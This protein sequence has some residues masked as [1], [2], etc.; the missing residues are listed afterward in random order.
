MIVSELSTF[1]V[2]GIGLFGFIF[3]IFEAST[4]LFYLIT[5]NYDLPRRQH[6]RELPNNVTDVIVLRK[7][8]QMFFLG[9]FLL[10]VSFI[11]ITIA[12]QLFT[13]GASAIL[14]SGLIDYS[15]FRKI[16]ILIVWIS[17]ATIACLLSV[18]TIV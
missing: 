5:K 14:I 17:I 7:V 1:Q 3:G 6:G 12:P 8:A 4:N 18:C 11:S 10:F 16:D 2:V 9:I 13:V 15:K